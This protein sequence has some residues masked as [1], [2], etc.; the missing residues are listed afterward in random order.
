MIKNKKKEIMMMIIMQKNWLKTQF[1]N[2]TI[3]TAAIQFVIYRVA[4]KVSC[5]FFPNL[6]QLLKLLSEI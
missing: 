5:K 3:L 6:H 4:Q 2:P 1:K